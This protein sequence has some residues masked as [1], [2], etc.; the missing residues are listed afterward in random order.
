MVV[1]WR[2]WWNADSEY[3][4][5][6]LLSFWSPKQYNIQSEYLEK[7]SLSAVAKHPEEVTR[8]LCLENFHSDSE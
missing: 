7:S 1:E 8:V 6:G 4:Q 3:F 5:T 2:T